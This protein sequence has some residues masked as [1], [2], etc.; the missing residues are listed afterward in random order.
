[1]SDVIDG[2]NMVDDV[3]FFG[4]VAFGSARRASRRSAA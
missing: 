3:R 4:E 1:M 2:R